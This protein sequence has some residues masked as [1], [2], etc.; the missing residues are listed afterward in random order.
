MDNLNYASINDINTENIAIP[1]KTHT[2]FLYLLILI[3]GTSCA[4]LGLGFFAS[5]IGLISSQITTFFYTITGWSEIL[6]TLIF[7]IGAL[8]IAVILI[9]Y[10]GRLNSFIT[11]IAYSLHIVDRD[12]RPREYFGLNS[13]SY[14]YKVASLIKDDKCQLIKDNDGNGGFTIH[15]D[16]LDEHQLT[17]IKGAFSI[18]TKLMVFIFLFTIPMILTI[19]AY[20]GIWMYTPTE[21]TVWFVIIVICAL[22]GLE[23]KIYPLWCAVV[24][25]WVFIII[26]YFI[27]LLQITETVWWTF[28]GI[29]IGFTFLAAVFYFVR[30]AGCEHDS[31]LF[32]CDNL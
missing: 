3:I 15:C 2:S 20:S 7:G 32:A 23:I 31:T 5:L 1:K 18:K 14:K 4:T 24:F 29:W 30:K 9:S 28:T 16:V 27:L 22:I 26:S 6:T 21:T 17:D 8:L 25:G 19:T 11:K 13:I 12:D 10:A